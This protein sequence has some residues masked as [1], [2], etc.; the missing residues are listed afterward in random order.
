[1]EIFLTQIQR[2][3]NVL[4]HRNKI[5]V[6]KSAKVRLAAA[7]I[8]TSVIYGCQTRP[9][10]YPNYN[11]SPPL[12]SNIVTP[13][14]LKE[15]PETIGFE[16]TDRVNRLA[17]LSR[18]FGTQPPEI[19]EDQ[20]AVSKVPGANFPVPVIR[21]HYEERTF[22]DSGSAVVRI[23][24]NKILD[25]LAEQMKRDLPDTSLVILGHTDSVGSDEYNNNLSISRAAAVM[26]KLAQ[27]GVN[28]EQMSTVGIGE[29]H[30]IAN[31]ASEVSRA[32]NRRVE[33]MLSRFEEANY[34]AIE[35]FPRN[36][37]WLNNHQ[38]KTTD[39]QEKTEFKPV[40]VGAKKLVV[41]KPTMDMLTKPRPASSTQTNHSESATL[42]KESN[43]IVT[44]IPAETVHILPSS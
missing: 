27:R 21:F 25:V 19:Q 9:I 11:I 13:L 40:D 6:N 41:L 17:R 3:P 7:I 20:V 39:I 4:V 30:P 14:N 29:S 12:Q 35:Q 15:L 33:F 37:E 2:K 5:L 28:L 24:S 23:D 44:I 16:H 22:F 10:Q 36:A 1:L 34:V 26:R 31:N 8:A 32:L 43:R 42:L 38:E 18:Q